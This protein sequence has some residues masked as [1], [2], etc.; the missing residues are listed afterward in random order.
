MHEL[1]SL[2]GRNA[3]SPFRIDKLLTTLAATRVSG[4][5]ADFWHFV[6]SR[7]PLE[8]R[9]ARDARTHPDLRTTQRRARRPRRAPSGRSKTGN[10]LAVELQGDRHRAQLRARVGRAHR[11][12]RR[13]PG[14]DARRCG[15]WRRRPRRAPSAD[16]RSHDRGGVRVAGRRGEAVFA[17]CAAAPDAHRSRRARA[18]RDRG[19]QRRAGT[20]AVGRRDRL[21]RRVFRARPRATAIRPTSS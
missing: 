1:I 4:L 17:F 16:P 3:L 11:A 13:V 5:V 2:R 20:G 18:R 21:S 7:G 9:R 14:H 6:Q 10:D 8:R 19:R 15:A 12:R